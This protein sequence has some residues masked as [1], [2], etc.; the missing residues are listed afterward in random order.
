MVTPQTFNSLLLLSNHKS[1]ISLY[2]NVSII[3]HHVVVIY[4]TPFLLTSIG[5]RLTLITYSDYTLLCETK[6]SYS[7]ILVW[8]ND[9]DETVPEALDLI[10]ASGDMHVILTRLHPIRDL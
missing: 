8:L 2:L 9:V 1:N 7:S 6:D 4:P 3:Q 10:I 5:S